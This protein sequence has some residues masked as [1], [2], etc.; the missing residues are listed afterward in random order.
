MDWRAELLGV[1]PL[2][3]EEHTNREGGWITV[4]ELLALPVLHD[5]P[6]TEKE[7]FDA[8]VLGQ[9]MG[10]S[11]G[12]E[13]EYFSACSYELGNLVGAINELG[14][15]RIREKAHRNLEVLYVKWAGDWRMPLKVG[16]VYAK[17]KI[18]PAS[19]GP[20]L[21]FAVYGKDGDRAKSLVLDKDKLWS[22][23]TLVL[24]RLFEWAPF[25]LV[26]EHWGQDPSVGIAKDWNVRFCPSSLLE[27]EED[28]NTTRWLVEAVARAN[29]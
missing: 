23:M 1:L 22:A 18:M 27:P 2:T 6:K 15:K 12:I 8:M 26:R 5:I 16:I 29:P 3:W 11:E 19:T 25:A 24:G 20:L 14:Q 17:T 9:L 28:G 21:I 13:G 10:L 4:T 7:N